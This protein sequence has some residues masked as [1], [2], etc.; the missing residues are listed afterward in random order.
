M[1]S[2]PFKIRKPYTPSSA[3]VDDVLSK[4]DKILGQLKDYLDTCKRSGIDYWEPKVKALKVPILMKEGKVDK[5]TWDKKPEDEQRKT[6][7][8][9]T[10][11]H[12]ELQ[13]LNVDSL[14]QGKC[15]FLIFAA[16]LALVVMIYLG[17]HLQGFKNYIQPNLTTLTSKN[18]DEIWDRV[19]LIDLKLAAKKLAEKPKP[20]DHGAT[21]QPTAPDKDYKNEIKTSL[22]DLR[23]LLHLL[24]LPFETFKLLGDVSAELEADDPTVYVTYPTLIKHLSVDLES[25]STAYFW[26]LQPW[27]LLELVFWATMGC[28]VGLLFYIAGSLEQGIFRRENGFMFWAE[29]LIAPVVVP[30][31]FFLFGMTGVTADF[32][33]SEASVTVNIGV[34]FIFGFAIRRTVGLLDNIKKR[35]FPD[36]STRSANPGS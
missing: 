21:G 3:D 27:R 14:K 12:E 28:L 31:A 7:D 19:R 26:T 25:L 35:F 16:L 11:T 13:C 32:V 36:P 8:L 10:T 15:Y 29:L 6:W 18:S 2:N 23:S 4:V 33:P 5:E 17:L 1:F 9:L 24:P 34:A 22:T 30:V 20:S